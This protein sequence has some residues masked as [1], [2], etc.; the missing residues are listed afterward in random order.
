MCTK[1]LI[2]TVY[3]TYKQKQ[4]GL[5]GCFMTESVQWIVSLDNQNNSLTNKIKG[6]LRCMI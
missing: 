1:S 5:T 3:N 2:F 6:L 4:P